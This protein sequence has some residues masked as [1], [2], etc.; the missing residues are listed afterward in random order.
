MA[1]IA[2]LTV[3]PRQSPPGEVV[4]PFC[5]ARN[6]K[7]INVELVGVFTLYDLPRRDFNALG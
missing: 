3:K 7:G 6:S 4:E 5:R 2:A 1:I